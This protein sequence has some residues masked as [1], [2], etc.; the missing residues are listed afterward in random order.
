MTDDQ[1]NEYYDNII[2]EINDLLVEIDDI[3][4]FLYHNN[5]LDS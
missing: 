3:K 4:S 1:K 2:S 5:N